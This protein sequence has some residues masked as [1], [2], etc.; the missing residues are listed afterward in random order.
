MSEV[1]GTLVSSYRHWNGSSTCE[2][3]IN[4]I[5]IMWYIF[6]VTSLTKYIL[7]HQGWFM[8]QLIEYKQS[9]QLQLRRFWLNRFDFCQ[10]FF[11]QC[12]TCS[13][14]WLF[15]LEPQC[16]AKGRILGRRDLHYTFIL[17]KKSWFVTWRHCSFTSCSIHCCIF[18]QLLWK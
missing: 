10:L 7:Q 12:L 4:I 2:L 1:V 11:C 8:T 16:S 17:Q 3:S 13:S 9:L 18:L 5:V 15:L 6:R 14:Y